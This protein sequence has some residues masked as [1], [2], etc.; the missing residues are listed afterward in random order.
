M[1]DDPRHNPDLD[2]AFASPPPPPK[3]ADDSKMRDN[4]ALD[5]LF[6]PSPPPP[7]PASPQ[8]PR[9]LPP[10]RVLGVQPATYALAPD[11][12]ASGIAQAFASAVGQA[13]AAAP[14]GKAQD[15]DPAPQRPG[16]AIEKLREAIERLTAKMDGAGRAAGEPQPQSGGVGG[17]SQGVL[18]RFSGRLSSGVQGVASRLFGEEAGRLAGQG[19]RTLLD[20]GVKRLNRVGAAKA[21]RAGGGAAGGVSRAVA[22]RA[23]GAVRGAA[24]AAAGRASTAAPGPAGVVLGVLSSILGSGGGGGGQ[25]PSGGQ[26]SEQGDGGGG[27]GGQVA[28]AAKAVPGPVG[29]AAAVILTAVEAVGKLKDAIVEGTARQHE[30]NMRY[31]EFSAAMGAVQTR[32]EFDQARRRRDVG[33]STAATAGALQQGKARYED[34]MAEWEKLGS[35]AKNAAL[36]V[37]LE[38]LTEVIRPLT[39]VVGKVNDAL[40]KY[41]GSQSGPPLNDFI[42]RSRA[43]ADKN[44]ADLNEWLNRRPFGQ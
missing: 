44:K 22:G 21:A 29:V 9:V 34:D 8:P 11:A 15:R 41:L 20:A 40:D 25:P 26:S 16:E 24:T 43:E 19:T 36:T 32:E 35:N 30:T 39:F 28:G 37:A 13:N 2:A 12:P 23:A 18:S 10:D 27:L 31:A 7:P 38:A 3:P 17:W 5:D 42:D 6:N 33:D 4:P 1:T 14:G